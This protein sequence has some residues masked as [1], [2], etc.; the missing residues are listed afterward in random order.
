M[1]MDID[2]DKVDQ[3]VLALLSLGR[4]DGSR[5]WKPFDWEIMG[6]IHQ[7]GYITDP[8]G[9]AKSVIFTEEGLRESERLLRAPFCRQSEVS[10][11]GALRQTLGCLKIP[12][13]R[14]PLIV[15]VTVLGVPLN[16]RSRLQSPTCTAYSLPVSRR[17]DTFTLLYVWCMMQRR[18]KTIGRN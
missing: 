14:C 2:Q 15:P 12:F 13:L 11:P 5:T 4:H 17:T 6:R 10:A 9:K 18:K 7:K 8:V 1:R 16:G 3:A